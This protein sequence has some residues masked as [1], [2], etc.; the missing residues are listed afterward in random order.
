MRS[1]TASLLLL[2]LLCAACSL[3][4][5]TLQ[6]PAVIDSHMVLQRNSPA[7][8][9]GWTDQPAGTNIGVTVASSTGS[10]ASYSATS[11]ADGSWSVALGNASLTDFTETFTISITDGEDKKVLEDVMFGDVI[12]CSGQSNMELTV[13]G[14][15]NNASEIQDSAN[16]PYLRMF[17]TEKIASLNPL[18]NL[19]SKV[20]QYNWSVSGPE[21]F[22]ENGA[23]AWSVF[24]ATCYFSQ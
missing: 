21:A 2:S 24:S 11:Q 12:L 1:Y 8:I 6:L 5:A 15:F 4:S 20:Q 10:V 23:G 9:W 22:L 3:S 14:A 7:T 16:Y 18:P 17:T 19:T 13:F